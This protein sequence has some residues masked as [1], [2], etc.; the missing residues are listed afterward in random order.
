MVRVTR[1][2]E[3]GVDLADI[4][5]QFGQSSGSEMRAALLELVSMGSGKL[6]LNLAGV[7]FV[8]SYG[9]ATLVSV[10]KAMERRDG[11][12]VLSTI[13][14]EIEALIE[15]TRLQSLFEIF[16]SDSTALV[17]LA[18]AR[19]EEAGDTGQRDQ[20]VQH[21]VLSTDYGTVFSSRDPF[22]G[23]EH[24]STIHAAS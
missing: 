24:A 18:G 22:S 15:L 5:G 7:T 20:R 8:D 4:A 21:V 12:V 16:P 11:R 6:V 10:W 19:H 3:L 13:S 1:D 2:Q 23:R 9:L 17:S 14:R